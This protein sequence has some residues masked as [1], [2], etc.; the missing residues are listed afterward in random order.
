MLMH[1]PS[2][3]CGSLHDKIF[4]NTDKEASIGNGIF[5]YT[6]LI[7]EYRACQTSVA[8]MFLS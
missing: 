7:K 3:C 4:P 1:S 6:D 2:N 5:K 8:A